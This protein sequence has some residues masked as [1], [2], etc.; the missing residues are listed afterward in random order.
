MT[1]KVGVRTFNGANDPMALS[2]PKERVPRRWKIWKWTC[3]EFTEFRMKNTVTHIERYLLATVQED[4]EVRAVSI[5]SI[6]IYI[7]E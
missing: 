7:T 1:S 3:D 4:S 6:W 2:S 5:W